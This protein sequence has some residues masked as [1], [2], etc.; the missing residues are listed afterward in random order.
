MGESQS[1]YVVASEAGHV[2]ANVDASG[3]PSLASFINTS[4]LTRSFPQSLQRGV[5]SLSIPHPIHLNTISMPDRGT[6]FIQIAMSRWYRRVHSSSPFCTTILC[7]FSSH[8]V[9]TENGLGVH[10]GLSARPLAES[11]GNL[12]TVT[13]VHCGQHSPGLIFAN[14]L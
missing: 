1:D 4:G 2:V 14:P 5:L 12:A 13:Y 8:L 3:R 9:R 6:L 11:A 7:P 10:S